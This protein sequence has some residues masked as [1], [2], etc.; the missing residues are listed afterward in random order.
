MKEVLEHARTTG[1]L[2]SEF[3][4]KE[5][6]NELGPS[7]VDDD[8]VDRMREK[9]SKPLANTKFIVVDGIMLYHEGSPLLN[10]FD[11]KFFLDAPYDVLKKRREARKGYATLEGFWEDPPGYFD[12]IVWP[13]YQRYYSYLFEN[14]DVSDKLNDQLAQEL[15]LRH[16]VGDA[17]PRMPDVLEWALDI[18]QQ[19]VNDTC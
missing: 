10:D 13:A 18:I 7:R 11:I 3:E 5:E 1:D 12:D 17:G 6:T 4:S 2:P 16:L 19:S 15:D 14:H 8:V 9:V